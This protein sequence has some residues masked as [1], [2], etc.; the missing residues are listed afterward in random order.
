MRSLSVSVSCFLAS[1]VW[2]VGC[3]G[4]ATSNVTSTPPPVT[5]TYSAN[6]K[7]AYVGNGGYVGEFSVSTSGQWTE[8]GRAFGPG[9]IGGAAIAIDPKYRFLYVIG[10]GYASSSIAMFT[11]DPTTGI[12]TP[13]SPAA[14]TIAGLLSQSIAVD[15]LGRFVYTTDTV[16]NTVTSLAINQSTGMLTPTSVPI[17]NSVM[18]T[19]GVVADAAGKFIYVEGQYG[20]L[21][22]YSIDQTTGNLTVVSDYP[23]LGGGGGYPGTINPAG[24]YYYA[25]AGQANAISV[26]GLDS[27][28]GVLTQVPSGGIIQTG[29]DATSVALTPN[30][31]YAYITAR[32][33]GNVWMFTVDSS[34][35]LLTRFGGSITAGDDYPD[36]ITIDASG[37]LAYV[38]CYG[39][40]QIFGIETDGTLTH[41]GSV[42]TDGTAEGIVLVP[43]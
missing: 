7:Y 1:T 14:V 32:S 21:A 5:P 3:G 24:T 23:F 38:G 18:A 27:Q 42:T 17:T 15:G 13:T 25:A 37:Q 9:S 41:V 30:G 8:I 16:S 11:I 12:L 36:Q 20:G 43:R 6:S 4:G 29:Q 22:S 40:V 28:T 31:K 10:G 33:D 35:G 26:V 19:D 2:L 39:S 34:T